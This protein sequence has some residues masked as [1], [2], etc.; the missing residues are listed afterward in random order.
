[1][2]AMTVCNDKCSWKHQTLRWLSVSARDRGQNMPKNIHIRTRT[3]TNVE[4]NSN[5]RQFSKLEILIL[6]VRRSLCLIRYDPHK[7][8][9]NLA[10]TAEA[11]CYGPLFLEQCVDLSTW[12]LGDA[13][14]SFV[15]V[16]ERSLLCKQSDI[17]DI[18]NCLWPLSFNLWHGPQTSVLR[19]RLRR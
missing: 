11:S 10:D 2:H 16:L 3:N 5:T 13:Q 4:N 6:K 8:V 9:N 1:M 14:Q 19:L 15:P 18:G 12:H 17:V 7:S